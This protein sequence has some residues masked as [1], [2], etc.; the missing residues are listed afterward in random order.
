MRAEQRVVQEGSSPSGAQ[1]R[2]V[3]SESGGDASLAERANGM[4]KPTRARRRKPDTDKADLN[5]K[6]KESEG[7]VSGV[8]R[9]P[10]G[11]RRSTGP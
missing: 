1:M 2:S 8:I 9:N 4:E 11:M 10:K 5:P 7:R 3:I 6:L